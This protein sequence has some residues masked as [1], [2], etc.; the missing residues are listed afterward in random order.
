VTIWFPAFFACALGAQSATVVRYC[1]GVF[2]EEYDPTIQDCYRLHRSFRQHVVR[3]EILDTA[4]TQLFTTMKDLYIS[5]GHAFVLIYS[6]IARSTFNDLPDIIKYICRIKG[7][8]VE[9]IPMVIVAN[10]VDLDNREV[11]FDQ[12]K[13][14]ALSLGLPFYEA[15][16]KIPH[17]IDKIFDCVV[18]SCYQKL[19]PSCF[20]PQHKKP[21][22]CFVM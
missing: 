8:R 2:V 4:G 14:F 13:Q 17:N 5:N 20:S 7:Q 19:A 21:R 11:W 9:E 16:A 6:V 1:Q 15:S 10:K 22:K 3:L 12:G 18:L